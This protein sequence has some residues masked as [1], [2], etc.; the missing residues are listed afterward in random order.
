MVQNIGK[1][2]KIA[3]LTTYPPRECG[4]ATFSQDLVRALKKINSGFNINVIAI[5]D[6]HYDYQEE[7]FY[8]INQHS[9]GDYIQLARKLNDSDIDILVIEHEYGIFGGNCGEYLL[10][11]LENIKIPVITC[12]HTVLSNPFFEKQKE[13]LMAI[14]KKSVKVVTMAHNTVE[15]LTTIY[16]IDRSKIE[17][18]HHG[19]PYKDVVSREKLKEKYGYSGRP[20]ISTFGL[21]SPGKG[22]EYGIQAIQ[23]VAQKYNDVLYLILGQTHPNIKREYGESYRE[24]LI[25]LVKNLGL[26]NNVKF[27]NRYL[28]KDEIIEYLQLS[29]IYMTPYLGKEQAVS[30]TLAYAVGY[31]RVVVSTPYKY[32]EEMLADGR[33]MLADFMNP[34][35]LAKCILYILDNPEEKKKMEEK[36]LNFGKNMTWENVAKQYIDLF[37]AIINSSKKAGVA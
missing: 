24:K 3:F 36:T 14:G 6:K 11:L 8:E 27:V 35:S 16:G 13:I 9:R 26:E 15:L 29:D 21:I 20:V 34:D 18:I 22:L 37:A 19:V 12:L 2:A 7:V 4:I 28:T 10:D 31:G 17:V 33:G 23:K 1:G 25:E 5:N 30:G 32:A